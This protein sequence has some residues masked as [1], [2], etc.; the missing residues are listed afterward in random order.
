MLWFLAAN[1][2]AINYSYSLKTGAQRLSK[3][4]KFIPFIARIVKSLKWPKDL[5]DET[6][7]RVKAKIVHDKYTCS[8]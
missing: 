8:H 3:I 4:P 1:L 2:I 7:G 6:I 5:S